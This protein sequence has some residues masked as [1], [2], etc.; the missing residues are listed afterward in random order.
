MKKIVAL[1]VV[2]FIMLLSVSAKSDNKLSLRQKEAQE[3]EV[4][5]K[6]IG[7]QFDVGLPEGAT[8]GAVVSPYFYWLKVSGSVTNNYLAWGGRVGVTVDPIKFPVG[9]SFTTE[10]GTTNRFDMSTLVGTKLPEASFNYVNLLL[11]LEIGS[12][13][14][15][16]FFV[17][18]GMT[19]LWARTYDYNSSLNN[20]NL[21]ISDPRARIWLTPTFKLGFTVMVF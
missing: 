16:R 2:A 6:W 4:R 11:G 3:D 9:P 14:R 15:V 7:F 10:L 12:P 17:R 5:H 1:F 19:Y 18:A 8:A 21:Q 13:N 20:P